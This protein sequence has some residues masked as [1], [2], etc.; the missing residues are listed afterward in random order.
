MLTISDISIRLAGRLL[1]DRAT[2]QITPGARVDG[3]I[4]LEGQDIYAPDVDPVTVRYRIGMV[5]QRPN[6][7]PKSI[8]DNVAYGP[9]LHGERD[10]VVTGSEHGPPPLRGPR[11]PC[12]RARRDP[13]GDPR[14]RLP[15]RGT[16][17]AS[18]A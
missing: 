4:L 13:R 10:R 5:F 12:R 2:V 14:A 6:P 11:A 15:E 8:F 1:I 16:C 7:F 3:K 18:G 9:R 17:S